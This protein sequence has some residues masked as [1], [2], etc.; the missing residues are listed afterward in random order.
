MALGAFGYREAARALGLQRPPKFAHGVE[1]AA[2]DRRW[3]LGCY[4]VSQQNTFT[5]R[6][7][8]EMLDAVFNRAAELSR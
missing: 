6:L 8:V 7:T 3:L 2:P 1:A 5:G 4:H